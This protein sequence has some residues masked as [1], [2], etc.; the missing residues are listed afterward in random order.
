M[1]QIILMG[2]GAAGS[3]GQGGFSQIIPLLLIFVVFYFFMILPQQKKNKAQKKFREE[4][5]KGDEI[6]T[7]SGIYGK[8]NS[9]DETSMVIEVEDGGKIRIDKNAVSM[10][11]TNALKN[12][13]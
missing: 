8:I 7:I 11:S 5:K 10:E 13:K 2:G 3:G 9:M 6:I 1:Y 12:K 4:L